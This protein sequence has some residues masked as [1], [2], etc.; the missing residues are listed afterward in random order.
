M[1]EL[2]LKAVMLPSNNM[3]MKQT[4]HAMYYGKIYRMKKTY[5]DNLFYN[6]K[7][8]QKQ[9]ISWKG[10][11]FTHWMTATGIDTFSLAQGETSTFSWW[12][13]FF[14]FFGLFSTSPKRSI[15]FH[16]PKEKHCFPRSQ[17]ET[18]FSTLPKT[19]IVF[20]VPKEKHC[21]PRSQREAW[22]SI[23]LWRFLRI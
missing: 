11:D 16:V 15:V 10:F 6:V 21:F 8:C 18:L 1:W 13:T 9:N 22:L 7:T 19:S 4:G 3:N 17:R 23:Q 5:S 14:I 12:L 2:M 20:H